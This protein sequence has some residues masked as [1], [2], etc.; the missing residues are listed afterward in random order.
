MRYFIII[1]FLLCSNLNFA[2]TFQGVNSLKSELLLVNNNIKA[3][4]TSIGDKN[5]YDDNRK[6]EELKAEEASKS[7][8]SSWKFYFI[9]LIFPVM[10]FLIFLMISRGKKG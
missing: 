8:M 5:D 2:Q 7:F 1:F 6:E 3:K 4:D 9:L 10:L